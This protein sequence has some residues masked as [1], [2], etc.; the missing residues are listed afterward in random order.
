MPPTTPP[1]IG[2]A[3]DLEVAVAVG[4]PIVDDDEGGEDDEDAV[5]RDE[6]NV[7]ALLVPTVFCE[8]VVN[9]SADGRYWI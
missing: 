2:R 5:F 6:V 3:V 4:E 8:D 9:E 7:P 1:M